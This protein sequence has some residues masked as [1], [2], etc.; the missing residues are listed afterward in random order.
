MHQWRGC[1]GRARRGMPRKVGVAPAGAACLLP[2]GDDMFA[3]S[4]I[5]ARM[6]SLLTDI[7]GQ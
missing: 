2:S 5:E 7:E 4:D 3:A 6:R 1:G